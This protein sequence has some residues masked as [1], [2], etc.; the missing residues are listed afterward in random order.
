[1]TQLNRPILAGIVGPTALGKSRL[2][3][4]LAKAAGNASILSTDS[5]QVYRGMDI[6]TAKPTPDDRILVRH[7]GIDEADP[8]DSWTVTR[9]QEVASA[10]LAKTAADGDE[11]IVVGG[12]GLYFHAVI[13]NFEVPP[14]A[15]AER[16]LLS[17][18]AATAEGLVRLYQR[19]EQLDLSAASKIEPN[20]ERRIVRALAVIAST[21][22]PFSSF[23]PGVAD[24]SAGLGTPKT[25]AERSTPCLIGLT[26]TAE[27]RAMQIAERI[28]QMMDLGWL[29]EVERLL[30]GPKPS[31]TAWQAIG[32]PELA[33]VIT[34][35]HTISDA[36]EAINSR[37]RRF[38]RRQI[39]W[40]R[41]D[42]RIR[43]FDVDDFASKDSLT[44]AVLDF[45]RI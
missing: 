25:A 38:A 6:G 42:P 9:T 14:A 3:M 34:G 28:D 17:D 8:W 33:A 26:A 30:A 31:A 37:T 10:C 43:W 19:L 22:R 15:E 18:Q 12:T 5:M 16:R 7:Y 13:D 41:R 29:Q 45:V 11:C 35:E 24:F 44:S 32:Y 1:M 21:G 20:N 40:F 4:D 39:A 2:A 23:G 36:I 27:T